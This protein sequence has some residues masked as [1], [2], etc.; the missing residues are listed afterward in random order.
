MPENGEGLQAEVS[1]W[2]D[3]DQLMV[4]GG[5]ASVGNQRQLLLILRPLRF[6]DSRHKVAPS[7]LNNPFCTSSPPLEAPPPWR[8]VSLGLQGSK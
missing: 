8:P 3:R 5:G 4:V 6:G 2:A 7:R 1:G